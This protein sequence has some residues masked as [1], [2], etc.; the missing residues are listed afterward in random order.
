MRGFLWKDNAEMFELFAKSHRMVHKEEYT[1][2]NQ[3]GPGADAWRPFQVEHGRAVLLYC[4][5]D[6]LSRCQEITYLLHIYELI[7]PVCIQLG[8][9]I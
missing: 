9:V 3:E 5:V 1:L 7:L 6:H 4:H 2:T 8:L